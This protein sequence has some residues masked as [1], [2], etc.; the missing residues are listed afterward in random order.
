MFKDLTLGNSHNRKHVLIFQNIWNQ[1][2]RKFVGNLKEMDNAI[3]DIVHQ[4]AQKG[5]L[6]DTIIIFSTDNG[7][8]TPEWIH[9]K[10]GK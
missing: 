7:V 10:L 9:G 1:K 8:R 5:V 6:D 2:R 3:G 4:F